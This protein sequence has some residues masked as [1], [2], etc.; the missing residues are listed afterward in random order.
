MVANCN[1]GK[2]LKK[3]QEPDEDAKNWGDDA[4]FWRWQIFLLLFWHTE[5]A[6]QWEHPQAPKYGVAALC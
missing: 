6:S 5:M 4:S 3:A 1:T 2:F